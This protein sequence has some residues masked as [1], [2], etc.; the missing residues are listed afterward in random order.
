M[1]QLTTRL[2][3]INCFLILLLASCS[4]HVL[5]G[6]SKT[7]T[8]RLIYKAPYFS[9]NSIDYVYKANISVYGKNL[10]GLFIAKR[11][12]DSSHRVVFTTEFGNSLLDVEIGAK[13]FKVNSIVTDLNKKIVVKTLEHD[14]RLILANDYKVQ[15]QYENATD[16]VYRS[17][18]GK[19]YNLLFVQKQSG[20]LYKLVRASRYK[21]K[22]VVNYGNVNDQ[23]AQSIN[24]EHK[25]IKLNI[26]LNYMNN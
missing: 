6:Y 4:S 23:L 16:K 25:N 9:N 19:R 3:I 5:D 24:M 18:D 15:A 11:I 2:L 14:F 20:Q 17:K 12:N 10:S 8:E 7:K 13:T 21:Q 22:V 1:H 26:A